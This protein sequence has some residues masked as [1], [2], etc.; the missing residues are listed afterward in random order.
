MDEVF[1][2]IWSLLTVLLSAVKFTAFFMVMPL[3]DSIPESIIYN[4]EDE[5]AGKGVELPGTSGIGC[6]LAA[7][8]VLLAYTVECVDFPATVLIMV[9]V[10]E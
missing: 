6:I 7:T 8:L 10:T 9:Y 2:M 5:R 3:T 1:I 4:D